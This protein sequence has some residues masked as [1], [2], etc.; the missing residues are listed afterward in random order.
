MEVEYELTPEDLIAFQ[1]YHRQSAPQPQQRG[2][3]ANT[4]V[5][6]VIFISV[7]TMA[8]FFFL[9]DNPT[10]AW[11]LTMVPFIGLGAALAML[12]MIVHVRLTAPRLLFRA[13][14][15]GRNAEKFLG[16]RRLSIDAEAVRSA[17]DFAA[18]TYLWHGIDQVGT[19]L[20]HAFFYINT[21]TAIVVPRR[22]FRDDRAFDEFLEAARYYHRMGGE[23]VRRA[24][25]RDYPTGMPA[26]GGS[27]GAADDRIIPEKGGRP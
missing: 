26:P 17:S 22:A 1:R 21:T 15:Q 27:G 7:A 19:T 3:P 8:S 18:S 2:G 5:G 25:A 11:Y 4:L 9:S 20:D 13:M 16:W 10:A 6:T 12:G 23:V 24:W 14:Q